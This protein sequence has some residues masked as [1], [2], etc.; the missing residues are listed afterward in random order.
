MA[1]NVTGVL[2]FNEESTNVESR[3]GFKPDAKLYGGLSMGVIESIE[4]VEN[5]VSAL[6]ED[7]TPNTWEFAG[8]VLPN[9]VIT[10]RQ[11]NIDPKDT[12]KRYIEYRK[13][14]PSAKN[15]Q[16]VDVKISDWT[17]MVSNI[18]KMLQHLT[19]VL[20]KGGV[21]KTDKPKLPILNY[22]DPAE[23]R[24]A[25]FKKFYAAY[26][27][28]LSEA[29]PETKDPRFTGVKLF[30]RVIADPKKGTFYVIPDFVNKGVFE[31]ADAS[32]RPSLELQPGD[33]I[34]L[35]K[36]SDKKEGAT[37]KDNLQHQ[38]ADIQ[39]SG[40]ASVAADT[41]SLIEQMMKSGM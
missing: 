29:N 7:G 9:I 18:W 37:A 4:L 13:S 11:V 24:I 28:I 21:I 1:K 6:N 25:D 5:E 14:V 38:D 23:K 33:S 8:L 16:G 2:N 34:E 12:T 31:I 32:K 15:K 27:E 3:L 17:E 36:K 35:Q 20:Y 10:F 22:E 41:D 26:V 30:M 19:N 39:P 40:T